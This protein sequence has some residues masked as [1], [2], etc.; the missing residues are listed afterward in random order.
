MTWSAGMGVAE[1][2]V[3]VQE[4]VALRQIV[5]Q[6]G[7]RLGEE[8]HPDHVHRQPLGGGEQPV[9]GGDQRAREVARHV[10]HGRAAAAQQRVLHLAHDRVEPVRDDREQHGVEGAHAAA[11][12]LAGDCPR[13]RGPSSD[14]EQVVAERR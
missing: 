7:H 9:V 13:V 6:V 1:V 10:E 14:L 3:V 12:S 2:G 11:T 5:V 4:G 8:L